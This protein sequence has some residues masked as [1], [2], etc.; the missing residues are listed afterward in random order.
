MPW[1]WL[2]FGV[3]PS[4]ILY[5]KNLESHAVD[6]L[7]KSKKPSISTLYTTIRDKPYWVRSRLQG[8]EIK[9]PLG[10][11]GY[12]R[13]VSDSDLEPLGLGFQGPS[14]RSATRYML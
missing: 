12:L 3:T 11:V 4:R 6:S 2:D 14:A 13:G 5:Q 7:S 10:E 8:F 9:F 1:P